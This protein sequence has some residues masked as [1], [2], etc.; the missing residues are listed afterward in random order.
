MGVAGHAVDHANDD[1]CLQGGEAGIEGCTLDV[2][3]SI[4]VSIGRDHG[5]PC[6][7]LAVRRIG[8]LSLCCS[9]L[10]GLLEGGIANTSFY[11]C[12]CLCRPASMRLEV[13]RNCRI[14]G[15]KDRPVEARHA[16]QLLLTQLPH[17]LILPNIA[18]SRND[19]IPGQTDGVLLA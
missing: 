19:F 18:L 13:T 4:N 5:Q 7:A 15:R 17:G 11:P 1:R 12:L 2:W 3:A 9:L 6:W 14:G 16:T 8:C 10:E